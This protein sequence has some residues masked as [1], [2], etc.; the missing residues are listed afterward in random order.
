MIQ[1]CQIVVLYSSVD[2]TR[3][4][5]EWKNPV[6]IGSSRLRNWFDVRL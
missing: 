4:G 1:I 3:T 2:L 5:Y 6:L